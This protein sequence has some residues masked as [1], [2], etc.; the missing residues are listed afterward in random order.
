[1]RRCWWGLLA[2]LLF[3]AAG[4]AFNAWAEA[5]GAPRTLTTSLLSQAPYFAIGMATAAR[6]SMPVNLH[7]AGRLD[8]GIELIRRN[9]DTQIIIDHLALVQ[10][11]E[12]P[13][14][15]EVKPEPAPKIAEPKA[16][17]RKTP[18]N[19]NASHTMSE[20]FVLAA[21]ERISAMDS[22]SNGRTP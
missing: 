19:A 20:C 11:H 21:A 15:A 1:M 9:P 14:P 13:K 16:R 4:V 12:P 18:V 2:C 3:V 17:A 10:P 5:S 7:I 6:L 22:A 8:Q